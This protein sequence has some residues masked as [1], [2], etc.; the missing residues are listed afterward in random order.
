[1]VQEQSPAPS[2]MKSELQII[3]NYFQIFLKYAQ[4]FLEMFNK[5]FPP[6]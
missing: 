3:R 1:M 5:N 6:K 4:Y 2:E